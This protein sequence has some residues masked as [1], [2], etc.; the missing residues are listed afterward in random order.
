MR[1]KHKAYLWPFLL[2]IATLSL[3]A[4]NPDDYRPEEEYNPE[5]PERTAQTTTRF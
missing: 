3:H 4:C 2:L 5:Y 1:T